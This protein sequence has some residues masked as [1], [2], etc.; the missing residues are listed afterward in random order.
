MG[1]GGSNWPAYSLVAAMALALVVVFPRGDNFPTLDEL[2]YDWPYAPLDTGAARSNNFSYALKVS[3]QAG[4]R[5]GL[6]DRV[7]DRDA[8]LPVINAFPEV[9][10]TCTGDTNPGAC[11]ARQTL[12][13]EI[14]IHAAENYLLCA[15]LDQEQISAAHPVWAEQRV[16]WTR[17]NR[18]LLALNDPALSVPLRGLIAQLASADENGATC[19]LVGDL[20]FLSY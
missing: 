1:S 7:G 8:W 3:L 19:N 17:L 11:D 13:A 4:L 12:A 2:W 16:D 15:A 6:T 5:S 18:K 14:G 9:P 10:P 20:I